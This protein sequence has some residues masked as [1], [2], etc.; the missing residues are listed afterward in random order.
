MKK[1]SAPTEISD[2]QTNMDYRVT[3]GSEQGQRVFNDLVTRFHLFEPTY[4]PGDV[5]ETA[6]REGERNAL[7]YILSRVKLPDER[8]KFIKEVLEYAGE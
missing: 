5:Y 7:L 8:E 4:H 2:E 3:F 6:F 1:A